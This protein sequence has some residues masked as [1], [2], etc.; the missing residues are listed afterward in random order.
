MES[1]MQTT[2]QTPHEELRRI[3]SRSWKQMASMM[4]THLSGAIGRAI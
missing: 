3:K 4:S 2:A 1:L